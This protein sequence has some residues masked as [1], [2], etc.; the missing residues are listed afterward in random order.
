MDLRVPVR[1]RCS[2]KCAANCLLFLAGLAPIALVLGY[3]IS[4]G[5]QVPIGDQ[6]WDPVYIAVK[7]QTGTLAARDFLVSFWG[8]RPAITRLITV[9]A[10]I[11]THYDAGMLRF[12]TFV[13]A[14]L[15]LTLA[16]LL[17]TRGRPGLIPRCWQIWVNIACQRIP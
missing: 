13:T 5:K 17:L 2:F 7:T 12:A 11:T 8:H 1:D 14:L 16:M 3:V 9:L 4:H 10:T 15:N 6:W